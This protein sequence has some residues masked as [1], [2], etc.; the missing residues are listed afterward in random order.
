MSRH[1][2]CVFG[3]TF[4]QAGQLIDLPECAYVA[5]PASTTAID[6]VGGVIAGNIEGTGTGTRRSGVLNGYGN[7]R[8]LAPA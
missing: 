6:D 4:Q 2:Y 8:L 3:F 7:R 1:R 5:E